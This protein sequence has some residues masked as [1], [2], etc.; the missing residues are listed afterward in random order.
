MN[1]KDIKI[2]E[3]GDVV[4]TQVRRG[5]KPRY[6]D[7][8][9]IQ[10]K[11][12]TKYAVDQYG[13]IVRINGQPVREDDERLPAY[14]SKHPELFPPEGSIT[15][16]DISDFSEKMD[17]LAKEKK[18]AAAN[19][20]KKRFRNRTSR[21]VKWIVADRDSLPRYARDKFGDVVKNGGTSQSGEAINIDAEGG[22]DSLAKI[23]LQNPERFGTWDYQDPENHEKW[24]RLDKYLDEVEKDKE[25]RK[26]RNEEMTDEQ[27]AAYFAMLGARRQREN[28]QDWH[29]HI[30]DNSPY[31]HIDLDNPGPVGDRIRAYDDYQRELKEYNKNVGHKTYNFMEAM[32]YVDKKDKKSKEDENSHT[33]N[34]HTVSPEEMAERR[35]KKQNKK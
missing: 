33:N 19:K 26:K 32:G 31:H 3:N 18:E 2:N 30:N 7:I 6:G 12:R 34:G 16:K 29:T 14:K 5:M 15:G 17:K 9:E 10:G 25:E 35:K 23:M 20:P 1:Y 28:F 27:K 22:E 24:L 13:D 11:P 4:K 21:V 8:I